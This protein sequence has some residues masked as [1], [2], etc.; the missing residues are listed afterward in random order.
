MMLISLGADTI[1]AAPDEVGRYPNPVET[2]QNIVSQTKIAS[3]TLDLLFGG[4]SPALEK[5]G[6]TLEAISFFAEGNCDKLDD[7][8]R[9]QFVQAYEE[10]ERNGV[11]P[12]GPTNEV[13]YWVGGI[14]IQDFNG[15][16][17]NSGKI[18]G[19]GWG[20]IIAS[21][22]DG[23][24][25]HY[26]YGSTWVAYKRAVYEK[27]VLGGGIDPGYPTNFVHQWNGVTI[28]NFRGG[29]W[30]DGAI[31]G[32]DRDSAWL[33]AGR[34]WDAYIGADGSNSLGSPLGPVELNEDG[35]YQQRFEKGAIN[36]RSGQ[37]NIELYQSG[38]TPPEM[39][40][41]G[42]E[43][44]PPVV[45]APNCNDAGIPQ[46]ANG[47]TY[48]PANPDTATEVTFSFTITNVGC[49]TFRPEVLSIG[50]RNPNGDITDPLQIRE[51]VLGPGESRDITQ[52]T[53]LNSPGTHEF[54]MAFLRAGGGW[55]RIPNP[56]G[57]SSSIYIN[58]AEA[59]V[60]QAPS[61]DENTT[62]P[63]SSTEEAPAVD[64]F[65]DTA[66]MDISAMGPN[67]HEIGAQFTV[68]TLDGAW[69]GSCTLEGNRNES[70]LISCRVEVP[71]NT[72]VVV[73]LDPNTVTPGSVPVENPLYFDTS[74]NPGAASHWGVAFQLQ[75]PTDTIVNGQASDIAIQSFLDGAPYYDACYIL[76]GYSLEGCDANQDGMITFADIPVGTYTVT[77]TAALPSGYSIPDFTITVT[78]QGGTEIFPAYIESGT[79]DDPPIVAPPVQ[80]GA[81]DIALITRDPADGRL[82]TD[83]CYILAGY[84]LQGCDENGD[85]QVTF[86]DIPYGTYTVQQTRTPAGYPAVEDYQIRV[87]Q[88]G[89]MEGPVS[90]GSL[91]FVVKQSAKQH[92]PDTRNV[93]V[94]FLDM[95]THERVTTGVCVELVGASLVGCDEDLIDGQV[96]FLDVR[97]GGPYE[98]RFSNLPP[99]Y[100]V[101]TVGGPLAV[102]VPS[103]SS[104]PANVMV[105]VLLGGSQG[106]GSSTI[107]PVNN[108]QSGT[109]RGSSASSGGAGVT[110]VMTF[111]GCPEGFDPGADDPFSSCTIPLDAPDAALVGASG[112]GQGFVSIAALERQYGG[113]YVFRASSSGGFALEMTGLE[114]ALRDDFLV[115]GVD[116]Q[117]GSTYS[118]A[119]VDGETREIF[120]FYY[121][122]R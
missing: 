100:E 52:T 83:V 77:Q 67:G 87:E 28:Q 82:L 37:T 8:I 33:V 69:L 118:A 116:G 107:Q 47:L 68:T 80:S 32:G 109:V 22:P 45:N 97:A 16:R 38:E 13:H 63:P 27:S 23:S 74:G 105:V 91:G 14:L 17:D 2:C 101:G 11:W 39:P 89:S 71:R 42:Y 43:P 21:G 18:I 111:R 62:A 117:N 35:W 46:I 112:V 102:T 3:L 19:D 6:V 95:Y 20:A 59:A 53:V 34:H 88:P 93:S 50:G 36:E 15:T 72:T 96:D 66:P 110:V 73:T 64:Q 7:G 104:D 115:Y 10:A 81:V 9:A 94:V 114:P 75:A 103:R 57:D 49:G 61:P 51:F 106:G 12:G 78:G 54:F 5:L 1:Y 86:A 24:I 48:S 30:G 99:G 41:V 79:I 108:S 121:Y 70:H 55:N 76:V 26:V 56:A 60:D 85:G 90:V 29:S 25:P 4:Y 44:P 98:L 40:A 119:L 92:A 84:S 120:V 122:Y 58:V 113:E 31:I 65:G